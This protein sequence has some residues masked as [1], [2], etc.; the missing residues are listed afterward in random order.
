MTEPWAVVIGVGN[1]YRGDDGVGPAVARRLEDL[2]IPGVFVTVSEGEP[3]HLLDVWAGMDLAV[4]VDAI[5]C[6]PGVP[7]QVRGIDFDMLRPP[8]A[9]ASSH[10]LGIQ[11]ALPLGRAL[12][13]LPGKIVVI[14]V[15]VG[16]IDPGVGLSEPVAAAVPRAI[17]AVVREL[18]RAEPTARPPDTAEGPA[19]SV[20]S[21]LCT[22]PPPR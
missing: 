2:R 6:G 9:A 8:G 4:V 19:E 14:A 13:R 5:L 7:G 12:G 18:R 16:C 11:D 10:A 3:T 21:P 15:D 17:E 22:A 20:T 1:E